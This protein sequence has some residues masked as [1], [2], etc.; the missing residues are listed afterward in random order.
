MLEKA[1]EYAVQ[2]H[3]GQIRKG[4][5]VPYIV[6]PLAVMGW[7][8]R[9]GADENLLAAGVLHD[10]VEDTDA[11]ID[12]IAALFGQDVA[13]LV[14]A[15]TDD[16]TLEWH[17]RKRKACDEIKV[18]PKRAQMLIL[19]DKLSNIQDM[20]DDYNKIGD[21]LWERFRFGKEH[22]SWYYHYS[23]K[24]MDALAAGD[25]KWAYDKYVELV[26]TVFNGAE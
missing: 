4:K 22:Q 23:V 7:L 9:M 17:E 24:C 18:L 1:I 11:A 12:D 5:V 13:E 25:T 8:Y 6:H 3:S 15:H 14:A 19:A 16:K 2:K 21:T 26:N 10:V 20:A